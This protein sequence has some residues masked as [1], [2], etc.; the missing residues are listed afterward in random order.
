MDL[1]T[2]DSTYAEVV[3]NV[4]LFHNLIILIRIFKSY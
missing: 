1:H 3:H 2:M 4:S